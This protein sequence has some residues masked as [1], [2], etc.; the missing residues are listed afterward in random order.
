[1]P[2]LDGEGDHSQLCE[3]ESSEADSYNMDKLVFK[4]KECSK[5]DNTSLQKQ[6]LEKEVVLSI[7]VCFNFLLKFAFV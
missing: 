2:G 5:H 3:D 7:C 1:M 4:E 6:E